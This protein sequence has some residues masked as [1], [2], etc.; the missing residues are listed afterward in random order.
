MFCS[1]ANSVDFGR[2]S[3]DQVNKEQVQE[4]EQEQEEEVEQ[5]RMFCWYPPGN[6]LRIQI[7][8]KEGI[9][10]TIL[11]WGW[12]WDH[13]TY[14]R[15]GYGFLGTS[16]SLGPKVCLKIIFRFPKVGYV[17]VVPW[18]VSFLCVF[19]DLVSL[20]VSFSSFRTDFQRNESSN[21]EWRPMFGWAAYFSI[22]FF[23]HQLAAALML[24]ALLQVVLE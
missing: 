8:P 10:P 3:F 11:L 12:D 22:E 24:Q 19:L 6:S 2:M 18:R 21:L 14:S 4:Q 1:F 20:G 16:I 23:N 5:D 15:E 13:Q 17:T 7:C 9:N